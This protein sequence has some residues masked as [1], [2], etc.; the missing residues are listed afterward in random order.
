M[1]V[2]FDV[3]IEDTSDGKVEKW[4]SGGEVEEK[5]CR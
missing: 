5:E 4:R 2:H 1:Q 3:N